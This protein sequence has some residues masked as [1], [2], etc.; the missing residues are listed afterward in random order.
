MELSVHESERLVALYKYGVLDTDFEERFDRLTR[1]AGA[2]FGTPIV[3]IS[4]VD[5]DRQW[6]KSALGL[7]VRQTARD[8]SFC[9]HA[10]QGTEVFI[11]RDALKDSR[12]EQNPLVTGDPH[13]RFYAGAP[14]L[15]RQGHALG[16]FCVIDR[17][18]RSDFP[19]TQQ[20]LLKDFSSA[21]VDF[22]EMQY[23]IRDARAKRA[24]AD[25]AH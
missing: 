10:I 1:I 2:L 18:P 4:L 24:D 15:S 23:A 16:T 25:D 11:V 14:L 12:F 20:Q 17:Q 9:T 6:F 19:A 3:L 8:I 7:K 21:V 5:K 22:F 13:I